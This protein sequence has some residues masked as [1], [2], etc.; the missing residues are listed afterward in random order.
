M[1]QI[2]QKETDHRFISFPISKVLYITAYKEQ[3][4]MHRHQLNVI[5]NSNDNLKI[6]YDDYKEMIQDYNTI[7][8]MMSSP[9]F[10]EI[11][12]L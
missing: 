10:E 3:N 7:S 2:F 9:A 6:E 1:I 4:M 5:F 8:A 11:K 12:T